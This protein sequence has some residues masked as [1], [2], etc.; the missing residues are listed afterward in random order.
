MVDRS[1]SFFDQPNAPMLAAV[2]YR[3]DQPAM[4]GSAMMT[5]LAT[6]LRS[7]GDSRHAFEDD[8]G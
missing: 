5:E 4:V 8:A 3:R 6:Q 2:S 7:R 1:A